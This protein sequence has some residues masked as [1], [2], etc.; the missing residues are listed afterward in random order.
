MGRGGGTMSVLLAGLA[1]D[2]TLARELGRDRDASES[3]PPGFRFGSGPN[4]SRLTPDVLSRGT[5]LDVDAAWVLVGVVS[6]PCTDED[7]VEPIVRFRDRIVTLDGTLWAPCTEDRGD[8]RG[9]V[10]TGAGSFDLAD[11]T[12]A[13]NRCI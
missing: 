2:D 11:C 1:N 4:D 7:A 10:L 3:T 5:C 13:S 8:A 6:S 12:R 9:G